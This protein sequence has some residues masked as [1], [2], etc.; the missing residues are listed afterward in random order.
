MH[1]TGTIFPIYALT[2]IYKIAKFVH[3]IFLLAEDLQHA[4]SIESDKESYIEVETIFILF[5][6]K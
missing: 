6:I 5:N 2:Y 4:G 3:L 1:S